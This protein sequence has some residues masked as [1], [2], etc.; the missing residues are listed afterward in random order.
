MFKK[1]KHTKIYKDEWLSFYQDEI[2]YPNGMKGTQTWIDRTDGVGIV[3]VTKENKILLIKQYRYVI[4]EYS[5]EIP[6]GGIDKGETTTD[7]AKREL[8]EET[9]IIA[10][11][12][13]KIGI[14]HSLNSLN[15]EKVT[16]FYS[17]IEEVVLTY[18]NSEFSE[19]IVEYKYVSFSEALGMIDKGEISDA[20]TANAIQIVIRKLT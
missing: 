14:F 15:T 17:K 20:M 16:I 2:E 5:W 9:G 8:N 11:E 10:E 12:F 19:D 1:L 3:A 18:T 7:A 6:G 13:Y 4:N